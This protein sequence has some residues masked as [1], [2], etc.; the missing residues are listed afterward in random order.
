VLYVYP[1]A[2]WRQARIVVSYLPGPL[3]V[4]QDTQHVTIRDL[5]VECSRGLGVSVTGSRN[6]IAGCV[7]RNLGGLGVSVDGQHNGV[8]ACDIH[9]TG[10]GGIMLA[11]G[12]RKTLSPAGNWAGNND[13]HDFN[14][15]CMTYNPGIGFSG[16]GQRAAHNHIYDG[17]HN[18]MLVW[19]NDHL[20]EFNEIDHMSIDMDDAAAIYMGRNPSEQG[21]VIQYNF[22]HHIGAPSAWGTAAIYPDDGECGIAMRGNVFY[23]CGHAGQVSMGAIF[24]NAGKDH[25]IEQNLFVDCRLGVGFSFPTQAHWE[26]MVA[27][28]NS[29]HEEIR[30]AIYE[31]VDI[32]SPVYRARYPHLAQLA[33]DFSRNTLRGNLTVRCGRLV[34]PEERQV[35]IDNHDTDADPGFA[36]MERMDFRLRPDVA[37]A[38]RF[39]GFVAPPFAEMGLRVDEYRKRVPQRDLID[40]KVEVIDRPVMSRPGETAQARIAVKVANLS[41][42]AFKGQIECWTNEADAVALPDGGRVHF[43]MPAMGVATK[44]V[45]VNVTSRS[46]ARLM[47]GARVVNGNRFTLPTPLQP[48]YR[49]EISRVPQMPGLEGLVNALGKV[50]PMAFLRNGR[51]V[52]Q[53]RVAMDG[54]YLGLHARV[55]DS[56]VTDEFLRNPHD[57]NFWGGPYLGLLAARPEAKSTRQVQQVILFP[58]G[59]NSRGAVWRFDGHVQVS[60]PEFHWHVAPRN[61]GYELAALIPLAALGLDGACDSF[62]F[63]AMVNLYIESEGKVASTTLFGSRTAQLELP[64][65]AQCSIR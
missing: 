51:E 33:K 29:G 11:G 44:E 59:P 58:Q 63:E 41:P 8:Q 65:L 25:L 1:T 5:I 64:T 26:R 18:A 39:A 48:V 61:G 7:I 42:R 30:R 49:C 20:I 32:E 62:L 52:G 21:N 16:V 56:R 17:P 31:A 60:A 24:I 34:A 9:G 15:V 22:F 27:R 53:L 45:T 40:C 10:Q 4:L 28:E 38:T 13:I 57:G 12:D 50:K 43:D 54:R 3:V 46:D 2:N 55:S 23:R 6:L 37:L 47:V 36:D 35:L 19:G 14:R